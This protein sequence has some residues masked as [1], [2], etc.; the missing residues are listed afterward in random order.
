MVACN[1]L[2]LLRV[3]AVICLQTIATCGSQCCYKISLTFHPDLFKGFL[4]SFWL[5]GR[6]LFGFR[7]SLD[8]LVN[9]NFTPN[10][11]GYSH[12]N[13]VSHWNTDWRVWATIA[14]NLNWICL[15][16]FSQFQILKG[17]FYHIILSQRRERRRGK[18]KLMC[19]WKR[20]G[21]L[22][23]KTTKH[24]QPPWQHQ[25]TCYRLL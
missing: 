13:P 6:L 8:L 25:I 11:T 14:C 12:N 17:K 15:A 24:Q 22:T 20:W 2:C 7:W 23:I 9:I 3:L 1:L 18:S 21:K 4:Q 10:C 5:V 16:P 19:Q